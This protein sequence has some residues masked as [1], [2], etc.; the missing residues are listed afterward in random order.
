[1]A[2]CAFCRKTVDVATADHVPPRGLFGKNPNYNLITVP[3]C[4]ECNNSTSKDDEHFRFLALDIEASDVPAA[5]QAN[6]ATLRAIRRPQARGLREA[7]YNTLQPVELLTPGGLFVAETFTT[8][9]N[10]RRL[11]RTVEKTI[12]GLFFHHR[13]Y[14]V[15]EDYRVWCHC[16]RTLPETALRTYREQWI[17]AMKDT[18][19]VEVGERVFVSVHR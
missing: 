15:P 7:F 19:V 14:P 16:L 12:R 6:E 17:P 4:R 13:G 3:A 18:P 1:M 10:M 8:R 2:I 9:L 11:L 5:Q